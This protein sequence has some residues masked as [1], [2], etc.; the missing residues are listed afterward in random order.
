MK[1]Y[2]SA[3]SAL[4]AAAAV[5]FVGCGEAGGGDTG[6]VGL[7]QMQTTG[8]T[9]NAIVATALGAAQECFRSECEPGDAAC[10]DVTAA[11]TGFLG[12]A[13]CAAALGGLNGLTGSAATHP[14]PQGPN[15]GT[16]KQ[17]ARWSAAVLLSVGSA[18]VYPREPAPSHARNNPN[19]TTGIGPSPSGRLKCSGRQDATTAL[20]GGF[21]ITPGVAV[22]FVRRRPGPGRRSRQQ[23]ALS[24]QR[25]E[26]REH[27]A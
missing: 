21:R 17:S 9:C 6:S 16:S 8:G 4:L 18:R 1:K 11:F 24:P 25:V 13:V 15:A 7:E 27:R 20:N 5:M 23:L 14:A 2:I 19:L 12:N 3:S 10:D 22:L 26:H